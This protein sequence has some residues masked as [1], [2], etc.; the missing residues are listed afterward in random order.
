MELNHLKSFVAVAEARHLTR[1]SERL[2]LSQ[3]AI[4]AHI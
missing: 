1:A 3:P 4:S 2:H